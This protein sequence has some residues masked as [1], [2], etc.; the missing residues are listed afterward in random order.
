MTDNQPRITGGDTPRLESLPSRG[1]ST[2]LPE[3]PPASRPPLPARHP[4]EHLAP[5]LRDEVGGTPVESTEPARS[6]E[7]TR[8]RFTRYQ[9]GW[10]A[11]AQTAA[12][13]NINDEGETGR[14]DGSDVAE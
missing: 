2:T 8:A 3:P 7:E 5:E 14:R 12:T 11:G 6:P 4:Q 10:R 13:D 9:Q 1:G